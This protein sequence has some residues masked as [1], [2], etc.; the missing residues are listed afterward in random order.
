MVASANEAVIRY[1]SYLFTSLTVL[2]TDTE[3]KFAILFRES[4]VCTQH[5]QCE[6]ILLAVYV[7][8]MKWNMK[9]ISSKKIYSK[10]VKI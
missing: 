9:L 10:K 4:I 5:M 2:T 1:V 6:H 7:V 3:Y 8:Y